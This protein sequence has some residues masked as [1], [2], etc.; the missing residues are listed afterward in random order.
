MELKETRRPGQ[1]AFFDHNPPEDKHLLRK[2][3]IGRKDEIEEMQDCIPGTYSGRIRA[4][5]GPSRVGKSHLALYFLHGL[6]EVNLFVV[7]AG[8]SETTWVVLQDLYDQLREQ[9]EAVAKKVED[10]LARDRRADLSTLLRYVDPETRSPLPAGVTDGGVSSYQILKAAVLLVDEID[11]LITGE[12]TSEE[13]SS[14]DADEEAVGVNLEIAH[15]PLKVGV[16]GGRKQT[17]T[18]G[19]RTVRTRPDEMRLA[20]LVRRL[21]EDLY[22]VTG[23]RV[24]IYVDDIDLLERRPSST[25]VAY[26]EMALLTKCLHILSKS[27]DITV[28]ASLRSKHLH[29]RDKEFVKVTKVDPL[30]LDEMRQIY[31]RHIDQFYGGRSVMD[32]D[33]LEELAV[34]ARTIGNFLRLCHDLRDWGRKHRPVQCAA[35]A[36]AVEKHAALCEGCKAPRPAGG[37][38]PQCLTLDDLR[39]HFEDRVRELMEDP[40]NGPYLDAIQAALSNGK[41]EVPLEPGVLNTSLIYT[42]VE[43]PLGP[44]VPTIFSISRL[45]RQAIEALNPHLRSPQSLA[46]GVARP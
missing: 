6:E 26:E 10:E 32:K 44:N 19:F 41:R 36:G 43:E 4:V 7:N 13:R 24:V 27:Q 14:Q 42:L 40:S 34:H 39:S 3:F 8:S 2:I 31:Q 23:R 37:W 1:D 15:A 25:R 5:H 38:S 35:C 21:S 16:T 11:Q 29:E 45:G 28:V 17:Q 12:H 46:S 18:T 30:S 9:I 22:A 20:R 33:C